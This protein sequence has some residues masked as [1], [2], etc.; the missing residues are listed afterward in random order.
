M[1]WLDLN[2]ESGSEMVTVT[3]ANKL[4]NLSNSI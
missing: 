1:L 3:D 2:Q 4:N